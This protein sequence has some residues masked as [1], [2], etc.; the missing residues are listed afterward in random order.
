MCWD[1]G[2]VGINCIH[3]GSLECQVFRFEAKTGQEC[4]EMESVHL[5]LWKNA[6]AVGK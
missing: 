2:V 5:S 3:E 6:I 1:S 4:N